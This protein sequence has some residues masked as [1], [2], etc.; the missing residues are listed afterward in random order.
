MVSLT[1]PDG[2]PWGGPVEHAGNE[3]AVR[4]REAELEGGFHA[5]VSPSDFYAPDPNVMGYG[6][7]GRYELDTRR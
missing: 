5:T 3:K 7:E 6:T 1:E 2:M 4:P